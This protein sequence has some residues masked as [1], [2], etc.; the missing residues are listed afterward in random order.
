MNTEGRYPNVS[1]DLR[2]AF[3]KNPYMKVLVAA[4]FYDAATPYHAARYTVDH[5]ALDAA[6][7]RNVSFTT[8][9]A[10]HMMYIDDASRAK[11]R[12]DVEEFVK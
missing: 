6:A 5:L 8:Y 3:V 11:L 7:R 4:G 10:G 9:E 12:K 2:A 1:E